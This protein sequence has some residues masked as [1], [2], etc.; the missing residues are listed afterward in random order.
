MLLKTEDLV[1]LK[2]QIR[3]VKQSGADPHGQRMDM[4]PPEVVL[5]ALAAQPLWTDARLH[6]NVAFP[7][8]LCVWNSRS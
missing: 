3:D 5:G 7:D 2:L 1:N 8:T 6:V 4:S